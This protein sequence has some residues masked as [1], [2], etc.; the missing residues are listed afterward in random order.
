MS[1]LRYE[2]KNRG[3]VVSREPSFPLRI[4]ESR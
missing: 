4:D 3:Y 2:E 1:D